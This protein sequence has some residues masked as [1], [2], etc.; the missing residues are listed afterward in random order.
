[1]NVKIVYRIKGFKEKNRETIQVYSHSM[2]VSKN[3]INQML[4]I[5]IV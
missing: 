2:N 3:I 4:N 5:N 1:M